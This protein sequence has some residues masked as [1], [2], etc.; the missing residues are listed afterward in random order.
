MAF[1]PTTGVKLKGMATKQVWGIT[2]GIGSGKS[3]VATLLESLG[4]F[5]I[6]T[7]AIARELT[8]AQGAAMPLLLQTF[9]PEAID[10]TGALN[11][12]WMREQAFLHADV[13]RKLEG[14]LHPLIF[15]E[16]QRRLWS[17][18]HEV[19][20]IEIPLLFESHARWAPL[21]DQVWVVE[22]SP[23][24]QIRRVQA[25]N[26]WPLETIRAILKQQA[27]TEQRQTIATIRIDNDL[28]D[29]VHL[30][31]QVRSKAIQLGL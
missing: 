15:D 17:Q 4:A 31:Q 30:E 26:Q 25:R 19:T 29:P 8:Q 20:L 22:A 6:D 24:T 28:D 3:R 12:N 14:L 7:D 11:R 18:N 2:G 9:G 10:E 1:L 5:R 21:L 23:E 16:V 13:K 27:T